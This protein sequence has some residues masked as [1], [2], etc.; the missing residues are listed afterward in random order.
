MC[1]RGYFAVTASFELALAGSGTNAHI[2]ERETP[3]L[4]RSKHE[5]HKSSI[6]KIEGK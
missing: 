3:S 4:S 1:A 5:L 6:L 2:G